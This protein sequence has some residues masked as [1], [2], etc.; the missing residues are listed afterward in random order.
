MDDIQT[1]RAIAKGRGLSTFKY[2][3]EV[4]KKW[5]E[6]MRELYRVTPFLPYQFLYSQ[7]WRKAAGDQ[8]IDA[9][10][11][12]KTYEQKYITQD[13]ELDP[14]LHQFNGIENLRFATLSYGET[15]E[16]HLDD[17]QTKRLLI[18]IQGTQRVVFET[19]D[20][21]DMIV[22]NTYFING[23]YRHSVINTSLTGDR[24]ALLCTFK[25]KKIPDLDIDF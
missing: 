7:E 14:I 25:N 15:L 23:C 4:N 5:L 11:L 18:V 1:L 6:E 22:G 16:T 21:V 17:P 8:E 13:I 19:G 12:L 3:G 20:E 24:I 10:K 9:T 2:L